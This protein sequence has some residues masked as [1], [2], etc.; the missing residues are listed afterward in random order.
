MDNEL[1]NI[2]VKK[3]SFS[4][5]ENYF[6]ILSDRLKSEVN[7]IKITSKNDDFDVPANYF[8][9]LKEQIKAQT[10]LPQHKEKAFETPIGYFENNKSIILEKINPQ[11][12]SLNKR[13]SLAFIRYAAA[14]CILLTTSFGIYLNSLNVK[15]NANA[16]SKI[17][18]A[19]L[20]L[21][22]QQNIETSDIQTV[23]EN[24]PTETVFSIQKAEIKD[25]DIVEYL[26]ITQ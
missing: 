19:D 14:A 4:I 3:N 12:R 22:L 20:E 8:K 9:N 7:L 16:L 15:T 26:N 13:L 1:K 10:I 11:R 5:P 17:P 6:D 24:I 21:Y 25:D 2:I 23:I 18:S